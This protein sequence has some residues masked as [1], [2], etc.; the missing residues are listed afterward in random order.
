[1]CLLG[2]FKHSTDLTAF[3]VSALPVVLTISF[4]AIS[5]RLDSPRIIQIVSVPPPTSIRQPRASCIP[6]GNL[7]DISTF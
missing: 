6:W 7:V 4:C 5:V 3:P 2:L 1:M